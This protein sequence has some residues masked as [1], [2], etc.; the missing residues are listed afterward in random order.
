M[1]SSMNT[2]PVPTESQVIYQQFPAN[3][4]MAEAWQLSIT[5]SASFDEV[6]PI[7]GIRTQVCLCRYT[8]LPRSIEQTRTTRLGEDLN[9]VQFGIV[10]TFLFQLLIIPSF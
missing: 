3:S 10:F 5:L 2:A 1:I 8:H 6:L 9:N 7:Q 4:H